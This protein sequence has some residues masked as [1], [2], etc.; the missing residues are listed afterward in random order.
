[1][2]KLIFLVFAIL[3][4]FGLHSQFIEN[5]DHFRVEWGEMNRFGG[6][7]KG[8]FDVDRNNFSVIVDRAPFNITG[9]RRSKIRIKSYQNFRLQSAGDIHLRGDNERVN[10]LGVLDIGNQAV[11]FTSKRNIWG[12]SHTNFFHKFNHFNINEAIE[13][14]AISEYV[15]PYGFSFTGQIDFTSSENYKFGAVYYTIPSRADDYISMGYIVFN[16]LNQKVEQYLHLLPY[17]QYEITIRDQFLTDDGDYFL[18]AEHYFRRDPLRNWSGNNRS[19]DRIKILHA[20]KDGFE[21]LPL[22][23]EGF[24]IKSLSVDRDDDG[25]LVGSG[26]YSDIINGNVRGTFF[27]KYDVKNKSVL[28]L[29]KNTLTQEMISRE[30]LYPDRNL[31]FSNRTRFGRSLN[32]FNTFNVNFFRKTADGGYITVAEQVEV[33]FKNRDNENTE[34]PNSKYDEYFFHNDLIVYKMNSQ[35]DIEWVDRI[36]KFQQSKNDGGYFLSTSEFLTDQR[37]HIFFNDHR[38][39]YDEQGNFL[40]IGRLRPTTLTRRNNVVAGVTID[41]K[42]GKMSRKRLDGRKEHRT[43]LVPKVS[44]PN[45]QDKSLLIYGNHGRKHRFGK[46][47]FF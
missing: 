19:S 13:G 2:K 42:S 41:L 37:I 14:E 28:T 32:N 3:F 15:Y 23:K 8:F 33:E 31:L 44:R 46:I 9:S 38:R 5:Y 45:I 4:S 34:T 17:K 29:K 7:V 25:N 1:M 21:E 16:E 47:S 26:F 43:V 27:L 30:G 22:N 10:L 35:G 18:I 11:A 12:R 39:N 40:E 6:N 20:T 24:V 36:P